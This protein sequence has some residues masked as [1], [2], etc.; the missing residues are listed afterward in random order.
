MKKLNICLLVMLLLLPSCV[1]L[2]TE[3]P[4]IHYY[5]ISFIPEHFE[6]EPLPIKIHFENFT[7]SKIYDTDKFIYRSNKYEITYDFYHRW[8]VK[9]NEFIS[10]Y[11]RDYISFNFHNINAQKNAQEFKIKGH[12]YEFYGGIKDGRLT[13]CLNMSVNLY[14]LNKITRTYDLV[15]TKNY[16]KIISTNDISTKG[17]ID[18]MDKNIQEISKEILDDFYNAI[19]KQIESY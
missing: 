16:N 19:Y 18:S 10:E 8:I 5:I 1:K 6:R 14:W 13:S 9:P 12:I 11:I 7:I 4:Q 17:F 3:K 2:T 15:L